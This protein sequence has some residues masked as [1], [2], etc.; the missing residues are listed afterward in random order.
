MAA[1]VGMLRGEAV[2]DIQH[3]G[4]SLLIPR[5]EAIEKRRDSRALGELEILNF[6]LKKGAYQWT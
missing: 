6:L 1:H 2:C 3:P 5:L 4:R